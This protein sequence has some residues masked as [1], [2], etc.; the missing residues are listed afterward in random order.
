MK[1]LLVCK[2]CGEILMG[3]SNKCIHCGEDQRNFYEKYKPYIWFGVFIFF[4]ILAWI[5]LTRA[6]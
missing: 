5:W 3:D 4:S 6:A 1:K 2:Y